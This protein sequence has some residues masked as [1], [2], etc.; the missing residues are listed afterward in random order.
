MLVCHI[1]FPFQIINLLVTYKGGSSV[2]PTFPP[3][4]NKSHIF[5]THL[6]V[7]QN[8]VPIRR[9]TPKLPP[10]CVTTSGVTI[11]VTVRTRVLIAT[12]KAT[13]RDTSPSLE[14]RSRTDTLPR[15]FSDQFTHKWSLHVT[16]QQ[17]AT[18]RQDTETLA[19][20]TRLPIN[21]AKY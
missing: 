3:V 16:R 12:H 18:R 17:L 11:L 21:G 2:S 9:L 14:P 20:R 10:F 1:F 4:H 5:L 15:H 13:S 19:S 6:A 7:T 8:S